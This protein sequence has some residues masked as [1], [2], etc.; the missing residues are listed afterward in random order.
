MGRGVVVGDNKY[1]QWW[2]EARNKIK[3]HKKCVLTAVHK[4]C[5]EPMESLGA[6]HIV[7][8]SRSRWECVGPIHGSIVLGL[9]VGGS[10]TRRESVLRRR[11]G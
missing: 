5:T 8:S 1:R 4:P 11:S 6:S 7:V 3:W 2:H 10:T 9:T